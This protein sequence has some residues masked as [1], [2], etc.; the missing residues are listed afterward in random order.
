MSRPFANREI[1]WILAD[2][3]C[4]AAAA[5]LSFPL[6]PSDKDNCQNQ[7]HA[8]DPC[9]ELPILINTL[10]RPIELLPQ[11]LGKEALNRDIE[12]LGEDDRQTRVDVVLIRKLAIS[13]R[14]EDKVADQKKK[15]NSQS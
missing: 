14:N 4:T 2:R 13:S 6:G 3:L 7:L 1:A 10:D 5:F 11:C 12:L 9:L 15:K 8:Q